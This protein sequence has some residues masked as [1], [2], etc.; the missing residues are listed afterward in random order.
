MESR[1]R[2]ESQFC[3]VEYI[4]NALNLWCGLLWSM[5]HNWLKSILKELII[6][7]VWF[8]SCAGLEQ[9][10]NFQFWVEWSWKA[11][12]AGRVYIKRKKKYIQ[13]QFSISKL[14]NCYLFFE[15]NWLGQQ[16]WLLIFLK[17]SIFQV[18]TLFSKIVPKIW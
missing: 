18:H 3:T 7:V 11:A 2:V 15:Y 12:E 1:S 16:L 9:G 13:D 10:E 4:C 6:L 14:F 8:L 5:M 17:T